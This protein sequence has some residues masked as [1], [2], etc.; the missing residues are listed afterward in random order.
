MNRSK[1]LC[2][3]AWKDRQDQSLGLAWVKKT[4][5]L[6]IV[7]G[8]NNI[9]CDN[10]EPRISKLDKCLLGWKKRS[11]SLIGKVLVLNILGGSKLLFLASALAPPRWIF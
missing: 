1:T 6:G 5:I 11:L 2:L 4:K 8:T 10:W 7:F 9:V 3:G